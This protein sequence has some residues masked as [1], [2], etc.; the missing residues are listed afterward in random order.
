MKVIL[1]KRKL[2]IAYNFIVVF[3]ARANWPSLNLFTEHSH[4]KK[5]NLNMKLVEKKKHNNYI[6]KHS[7]NTI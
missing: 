4:L 6:N 7:Q 5:K 3:Q 1:L 2:V